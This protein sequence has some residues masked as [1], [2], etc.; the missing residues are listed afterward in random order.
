MITFPMG[1]SHPLQIFLSPVPACEFYFLY[2]FVV[3]IPLNIHFWSINTFPCFRDCHRLQR[4]ENP[5]PLIGF[6]TQSPY[7]NTKAGFQSKATPKNSTYLQHEGP[8]LLHSSSSRGQVHQAQASLAGR[9]IIYSCSL[10]HST[11]SRVLLE[12]LLFLDSLISP[13]Q[14]QV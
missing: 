5:T 11:H 12:L 9:V 6:I 14:L 8:Q 4:N 2:Q 7:N 3:F 10:L 13:N 1:Y